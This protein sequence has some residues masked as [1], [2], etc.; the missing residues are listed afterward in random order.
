[1]RILI[2]GVTGMLGHALFKVLE[3]DTHYEVWG[4][5]RSNEARRFFSEGVQSRLIHGVDVQEQHALTSVMARVR[6][7]V[8]INCVGLI[9]QLD[10][11]NDPLVAL[12]INS[13]LPHRL[14]R[15]CELANA[16]LIHIS[17]DCVFSG[18]RGN[19]KESDV[20]DAEDLYG[21]SKLLGEVSNAAHAITIRTSMIGHELNSRNALLEWFLAQQGHVQGYSNAIFSGLPTVELARVVRDY[22]IPAAKLNGVFHVSAQPIAK[23]DL[24]G[25]IAKEYAKDIKIFPDERVTIDRSLNSE[26]FT[27]MTGYHA[28]AWPKLIN[29]MRQSR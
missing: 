3:D 14:A 26:Y 5:L 27:R 28:P 23:R 21:R 15:L 18:N 6:P 8:V 12:P 20:P 29:L 24:L 7:Q 25:L 16:R 4:T 10:A 22:I 9:K 13:L 11:A 19:Y 2:L 17:T 1:M